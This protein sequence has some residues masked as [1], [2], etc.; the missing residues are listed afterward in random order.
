MVHLIKSFDHSSPA[1]S[2][3]V[4]EFGMRYYLGNE[5][6]QV[7]WVKEGKIF[8]IRVFQVNQIESHEDLL[9]EIVSKEDFGEG[10]LED[11][12]EVKAVPSF[13][14]SP[15][16]VIQGVPGNHFRR[17]SGMDLP[18]A[19]IGDAN[20]FGDVQ[21]VYAT[22]NPDEEGMPVVPVANQIVALGFAISKQRTGF[23]LVHLMDGYAWI[24]VW[25][26][27]K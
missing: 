16:E 4:S 7:A 20:P 13:V 19:Q 15:T 5:S 22:G 9:A 8:G 25:K 24:G 18:D 12:V 26:T 21:I 17:A 1:L 10:E 2:G 3:P 6:L 23:T 11:I 14:L 27:G